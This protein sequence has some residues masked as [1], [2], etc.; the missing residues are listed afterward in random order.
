M[1]CM[2]YFDHMLMN[3]GAILPL[4]T[5]RGLFHIPTHGPYYIGQSFYL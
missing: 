4:F 2:N 3:H 5:I 1:V